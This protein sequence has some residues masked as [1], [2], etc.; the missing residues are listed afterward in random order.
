MAEVRDGPANGKRAY[1][2]PRTN[3]ADIYRTEKMRPA[4][5]WLIGCIMMTTPIYISPGYEGKEIG[6]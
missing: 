1:Y 4:G 6:L 5:V 3:Y 2:N